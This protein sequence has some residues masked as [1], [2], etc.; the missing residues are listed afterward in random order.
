MLD[1][2]MIDKNKNTINNIDYYDQLTR[3]FENDPSNTLM[4]IRSFANYVPRQV[5]SDFLVRY[6]LFKMV[7]NHAGS[8]LEFGVFNGQGLMS[9][10]QFS[11]ILEPN[12]LNRKIF[13]FDTFNGFEGIS[14]KDAHGSSPYLTD[15]GFKVDSY[16]RLQEA[17]H[18]FDINRFIGHVP[19]V[20]LIKGDVTKTLDKFL[21]EN[22][23]LIISLLYLDMDIYKPTKYVLEKLLSRVPKGG[24]VAFD[25]INMKEYPGESLA[26]M[27]TVDLGTVELKKVSF[28]SRVSYFIK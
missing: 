1:Q 17:I 28:S 12:N 24:V 8:I 6:E 19:K 14:I 21:E 4:K 18:L 16:S 20:E 13:G 11:A 10:A 2:N 3:F 26:L 23:H 9:F 15:G 5:L 25:E 22:P 7:K 27:E